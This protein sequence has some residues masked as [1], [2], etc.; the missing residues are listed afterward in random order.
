VKYISSE[1][2]PIFFF[3]ARARKM[4][5]QNRFIPEQYCPCGMFGRII[6]TH[7]SPQWM[8]SCKTV[9][10]ALNEQH[11]STRRVTPEGETDSKLER[12]RSSTSFFTFNNKKSKIHCVAPCVLNIVGNNNSNFLVGAP[13]IAKGD[14]SFSSDSYDDSGDESPRHSVYI[15]TTAE[16]SDFHVDD[17]DDFFII[18]K[19]SQRISPEYEEE[20]GDDDDKDVTIDSRRSC[21]QPSHLFEHPYGTK[22]L[23]AICEDEVEEDVVELNLKSLFP[24][25]LSR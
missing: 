24:T 5:K 21:Q 19:L 7:N 13:S 18:T 8:K 1:L 12:R 6:G 16:S 17:D 25:T 3:F 10:R 4:S 2:Q 22:P 20:E 15:T 11:K 9:V 23:A 14:A